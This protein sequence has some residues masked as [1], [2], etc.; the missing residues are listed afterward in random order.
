MWSEYSSSK[1]AV[2]IR[3]SYR[4][5]RASLPAFVEIGLV[6]YIDYRTADLPSCP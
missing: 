3:T 1:D 2:A 4:L 6:R 5:L